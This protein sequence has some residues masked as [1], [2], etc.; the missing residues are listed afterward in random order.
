MSIVTVTAG[1]SNSDPGACAFGRREADI[2][3]DMR[4]MVKVY[5]EREGLTVRTDGDDRKENQ[6]LSE[7]IRLIKGSKLAVEFHCNAFS[8]P[9]AG[10][11]E[12]L[13]QDKDKAIAKAI[14]KAIS[15]T[16][17][18]AVRGADGGW[19]SEGSGQHSRL[20]Y[21]RNGGV[22]VELFFISNP[23]EL[24]VWDEKKWLVAKAVAKAIIDHVK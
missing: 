24:K 11:T 1:H 17:G 15:E 8:K 16:M 9:T 21:V 7:A 3:V 12:V 4:E 20:G 10:G 6:T 13:A 5:L 18:I 22:I 2:A 19:K 14:C 23:N